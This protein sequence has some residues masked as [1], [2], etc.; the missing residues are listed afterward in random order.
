MGSTVSK[1]SLEI[2]E[3][4]TS[5]YVIRNA[6][7]QSQPLC[8]RLVRSGGWEKKIFTFAAHTREGIFCLAIPLKHVGLRLSCFA[9]NQD[10][11]PSVPEHHVAHISATC[12]MPFACA[13]NGRSF[14][15]CYVYFTRFIAARA[16]ARQLS[17]RIVR[18]DEISLVE[19]ANKA[20]ENMLPLV[21]KMQS[22]LLCLSADGRAGEQ[23]GAI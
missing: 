3:H 20:R 12:A 17:L 8:K 9:R 16:R 19:A 11:F 14:A 2:G 21:S 1:E 4:T 6:K 7:N 18:W 13:C 15:A 5:V 10:D 22:K 23:C